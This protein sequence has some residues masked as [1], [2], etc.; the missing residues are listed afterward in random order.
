MQIWAEHQTVH[1]EDTCTQKVICLAHKSLSEWEDNCWKILLKKKFLA[2]KG[3]FITKDL[4]KRE[5]T[6]G[7]KGEGKGGESL[8]WE[9]KVK[10]KGSD[11]YWQKKEEEKEEEE[12]KKAIK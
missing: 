8:Q 1:G 9:K 4:R 6:R 7:K 5:T 3:W 11:K 10:K 12:K 2:Y